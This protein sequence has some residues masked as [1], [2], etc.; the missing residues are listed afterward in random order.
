[1][2]EEQIDY[3]IHDLIFPKH[4]LTSVTDKDGLADLVTGE[5][6]YLPVKAIE[7]FRGKK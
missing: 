5:H 2:E 1:M 4:V 3:P 7:G 6:R